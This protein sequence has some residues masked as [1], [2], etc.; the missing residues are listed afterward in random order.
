[1]YKDLQW[2]LSDTDT[3]KSVPFSEVSY[4]QGKS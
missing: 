1:M 3:K 2:N 4:V